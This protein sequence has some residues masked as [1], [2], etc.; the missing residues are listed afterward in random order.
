MSDSFPKPQPQFPS[1]DWEHYALFEKLGELFSEI[2][3]LFRS[4]ISV[5]G[6]SATEI[7]AFGAVLGLT[8]EQEVIRTLNDLRSSWDEEGLYHDY[9]FVRQ[10]QTFPDVLLMNKKSTHI[11]M[12]IELKSWYLLAKE[13]EP[14]FR[15][16]VT[17]TACASQ[18]LLVIVPWALSN[19]LSGTPIIFK[20]YIT[21]ARYAAEYR[22]YW[23]QHVRQSKSS[24]EI[25]SPQDVTPY[26][27]ARTRMIDNPAQDGGNNF[28][29]IARTGLLDEYMQNFKETE[30]SG[31][32]VNAWRKFLKEQLE[33]IDLPNFSEDETVE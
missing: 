10:A 31:I 21:L 12:G 24:N 4:T 18:D 15:Y 22:N 17:P 19:V 16:Q 27:S 33:E 9:R 32:K 8:I 28:G 7:Y 5:S 3:S 13:G 2:P 11:M 30:L 29:C 23:W 26:P 14:S 6:I 20:P 1:K 25:I